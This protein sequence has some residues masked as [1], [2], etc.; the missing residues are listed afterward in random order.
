M[1]KKSLNR[2]IA[3][4]IV[5]VLFLAIFGIFTAIPFLYC[6]SNAF[7]PLEQLYIFPPPLFVKNP[8]LDNFIQLGQLSTDFYVP[9]SRYIFNSILV[10]VLA[11]G[12][13]VFIASMA[14]YPLAKHKFPGRYL[15]SS[16]VILSLLF[17]QTVTY[18]PQYII[19]A[20]MKILNTYWAIILPALAYNLGLYLMQNFMSSINNSIIEAARIDG[21]GEWRVYWNIVMPNCKPA[22]ITLIIL[23]FQ[24]VWNNSGNLLIYKEQLKVL[25]SILSAIAAS[26]SSVA[27]QGVNAAALLLLVIPPMLIFLLSEN[28]VIE[29]Y[30]T[31]GLKD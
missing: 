14:A 7:K 23:S 11:T 6:F 24:L 15:I 12:G 3:G 2:S 26:S 29:T 30:T 4:N 16:T 9:L 17:A 31:S 13:H 25:P 27:R 10:S 8:T 28:H 21:A 18:V 19:M 5:M 22:W 1:F 20:R